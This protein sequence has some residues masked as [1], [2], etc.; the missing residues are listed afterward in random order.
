MKHI[1]IKYKRNTRRKL[2]F[3]FHDSSKPYILQPCH[4]GA[5]LGE[6]EIIKSVDMTMEVTGRDRQIYGLL[7]ALLRLHLLPT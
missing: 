6:G 3:E 4:K 2:T 5:S 7:V 1:E